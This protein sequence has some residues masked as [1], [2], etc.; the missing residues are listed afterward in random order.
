VALDVHPASLLKDLGSPIKFG[1]LVVGCSVGGKVKC[2]ASIKKISIS[3]M[4]EQMDISRQS[5]HG[6]LKSG[7]PTLSS[8]IRMADVLKVHKSV[9]VSPISD[10]EWIAF[11]K[12][13]AGKQ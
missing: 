1:E 12:S 6:T 7:N 8:I 11:G 2:L 13:Q 5:L 4:A 9:L 10:K 3:D